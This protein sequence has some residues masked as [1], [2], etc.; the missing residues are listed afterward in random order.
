MNKPLALFGVGFCGER[1]Y[2]SNY[3]TID[4]KVCFENNS[5]G[6]D[7]HGIPIV[8][9]DSQNVRKYF[10]IITIEDYRGARDQLEGYGLKEFEDFVGW[11]F[12]RKK[13]AVIHANCYRRIWDT[14]LK[15]SEEFNSVYTIYDNPQIHLNTEKKIRESALNHCDLLITQYIRSDNEF[16]YFLSYEYIKKQVPE[17]CRIVVIPNLFGLG[18]AFFPQARMLHNLEE[19]RNRNIF[20]EVDENIEKL[21]REGNDWKQIEEKLKRDVYKKEDIVSNFKT[22]INR[23]LKR[24]EVW[25]IKISDFILGNYKTEKIF[26]DTRHPTNFVLEEIIRRL[27]DFLGMDTTFQH[28]V[29]EI[30][31]EELPVYPCVKKA[32]GLKWDIENIRNNAFHRLT[33]GHMDMGQYIKEYIYWN[34]T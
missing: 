11:K 24:E 25:D 17:S 16:G 19:R 13:V 28:S 29:D 26:F 12:F 27:L 30:S 7:F 2:F 31:E 33:S 14:C 9:P 6:K 18:I 32:L 3:E 23:I 22:Y 8:A 5:S 10:I 20:P 34:H 4:I 15:S 21:F 1:F